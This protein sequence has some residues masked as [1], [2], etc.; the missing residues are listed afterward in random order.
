KSI[1]IDCEMVGLGHLG[2]ESALAR[3]SLVNYHGHILLDTFVS[4]KVG[5]PV[6]DFRTW[7]SGIRAQDLKG[8]PDF[9]SVQKQVSDLLTGRVLIGH[10]ISN[11]LQALLLSHPATMIR[12]TQRCKPLQE[13]AKNKRPGLKKL[14]QLELGLEIQKGSH[15]SV[16]DARATMAL[17]RLHKNAWD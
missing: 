7:I 13:I 12:D 10:A 14:C 9:A 17:F 6:T 8:A 11:D 15:S 2:S 16:T 1:A 3:V 4:P 5:E